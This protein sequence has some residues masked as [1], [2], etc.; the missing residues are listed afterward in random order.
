MS[1]GLKIWKEL[2]HITSRPKIWGKG[3][4][5]AVMTGPKSGGAYAPPLTPLFRHACLKTYDFT[6]SYKSSAEFAELEILQSGIALYFVLW[7]LEI[8][9]KMIESTQ[10]NQINIEFIRNLIRILQTLIQEFWPQKKK[11]TQVI[12]HFC[13]ESEQTSGHIETRILTATSE[14]NSWPSKL[15]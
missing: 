11:K 9:G 4:G 12:I 5:R 15:S 14:K 2:L 1:Q 8:F 13:Q 7:Y 10:K 3:V 6:L